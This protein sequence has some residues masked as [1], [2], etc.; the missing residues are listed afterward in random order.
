[1]A[2]RLQVILELEAGKYKREAREAATATG[3]IGTAATSASGGAGKMASGLGMMATAAKAAAATLAAVAVADFARDSISAAS[4]LEESVN[5]V[6]KTFGTA[7][8]TIFKFGEVTA[9]AVGLSTREFQQL[10]VVTGS[11]LTNLGF[12]AE[13]AGTETV[14]LTQRA[15][16]MAS[17]FNTDVGTALAAINSALKGEANPIEQFGV[18]LSDATVRAKA[19]ELG[20]AE[21][22]AAVDANGKAVATLSLIYE[23]TNKTAGDFA[24]TSNSLANSQRRA[25][26]ALENA[27][28]RLGRAGTPILANFLDRIAEGMERIS[29]A[30]GDEAARNSLTFAESLK[31]IQDEA[32][33]GSLTVEDLANSILHMANNADLT[34]AEV[35]TLTTAAGLSQEAFAAFAIDMVKQAEAMGVAPE[36]IEELKTAL[37]GVEPAI[38][39][40]EPPLNA[41]GAASAKAVGPLEDLRTA[42]Q[43]AADAARNHY[44]A[45]QTLT[46]RLAAAIN[47]AVAA[48]QALQDMEDAQTAAKEAADEH[49]ASSEEAAAAQLELAE[50]IAIA[51]GALA[52]FGL[53]ADSSVRAVAT[54][55]GITDEAA[56]TLLDTLGLL[57]GTTV[58]IDVALRQTNLLERGIIPEGIGIS[59]GTSTTVV[60]SSIGTPRAFGGPVTAGS[61]Y[62]VGERGPELFVP[63]VSG[64]I[65]ADR[66]WGGSKSVTIQVASPT[67][68]LAQDLQYA[69]LLANIATLN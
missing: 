6:Q 43:K 12:D 50:K 39:N 31:N 51:N 16:D 11:M 30:T 3:Q 4:N 59:S 26:A 29:A 5:A 20:L 19:V 48:Y 64:S 14:R 28:A 23:Q 9:Q 65:N 69:A 55:L 15:S 44:E 33:G 47:P 63:S 66:G 58:T 53:S 2:E 54:A 34:S 46:S 13:R 61:P 21:T 62:L 1:M 68:N 52:A 8:D 18:K 35:E 38:E 32:A 37:Y 45:I 49:G 10:S 57:D 17:V 27:Q 67:N 25:A 36:V 60:R 24:Q 22:T 41:M 40:L 7:S 42:Q 56:R